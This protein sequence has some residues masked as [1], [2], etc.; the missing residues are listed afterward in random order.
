MK[1]TKQEKIDLWLKENQR[2]EPGVFANYR[3]VYESGGQFYYDVSVMKGKRLIGIVDAE[4]KTF[5]ACP[6]FTD[7]IEAPVALSRQ[8][9]GKRFEPEKFVPD[10]IRDVLMRFGCVSRI[11][12]YM[13]KVWY[14]NNISGANV[15][16]RDA[17]FSPIPFTW[18]E[19]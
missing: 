10:G 6:D 5:L 9:R 8:E 16:V 2:F 12:Y 7:D 3:I 4:A 17:G 19:L 13:S 14:L 1:M 18:E 11:G 15:T